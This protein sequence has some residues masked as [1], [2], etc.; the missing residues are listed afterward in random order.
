MTLFAAL[1][2]C[3]PGHVGFASIGIVVAA[4]LLAS[5]TRYWK[6]YRSCFILF[7][8]VLPAFSI[9]WLYKGLL[10]TSLFAPRHV[11]ALRVLTPVE[12]PFGY[13]P[14]R[15]GTSQKGVDTGYFDG[16][17]NAFTPDAIDRKISELSHSPHLL[18]P[19][20]FRQR[21]IYNPR[22]EKKLIRFLFV[23]PYLTQPKHTPAVWQPL[24]NAIEEH[25]QK[26]RDL[27]YGYELWI[28]K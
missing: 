26:R 17:D 4:S 2:R 22:G 16:L 28:A 25:Y 12:A 10:R 1:G 7:F 21:C 6:L 20:D 8:L 3:D 24:C 15:L 23:Y 18:I 9:L 5:N 14:N 19:Q 11:E 27:D 13:S